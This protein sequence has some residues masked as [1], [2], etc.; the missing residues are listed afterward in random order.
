MDL[1]TAATPY[2]PSEADRKFADGSMEQA[3]LQAAAYL[4][5]LLTVLVEKAM[6]PTASHKQV[7][8]ATEFVFRASGLAKRQEEVKTGPAFSVRIVLPGQ[9][10][11]VV[12]GGVATTQVQ[13]ADILDAVPAYV[14]ALGSNDD[15]TVDLSE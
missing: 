12:I 9:N 2:T 3:R 6:D 15:L 11:E 10:R 14:S 4:P 1:T 5:Q 7:L 13:E 8:D